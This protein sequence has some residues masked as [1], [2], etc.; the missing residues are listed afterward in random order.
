MKSYYLNITSCRDVEE[1]SQ[2]F[3]TKEPALVSAINYIM[4]DIQDFG[5][6]NY[7]DNENKSAFVYNLIIQEKYEEAI[8]LYGTMILKNYYIDFCELGINTTINPRFQKYVDKVMK[9]EVFK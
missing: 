9:M 7:K 1:I 5:V 3:S 4:N 2:F 6:M 8:S